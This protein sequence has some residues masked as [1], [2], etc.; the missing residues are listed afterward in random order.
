MEDNSQIR[1]YHYTKLVAMLRL[2]D[3]EIGEGGRHKEHLV[4]L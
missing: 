2:S 3:V 4:T 1:G